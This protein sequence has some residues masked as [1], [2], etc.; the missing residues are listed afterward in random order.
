MADTRVANRT[1]VFAFMIGDRLF[2]TVMVFVPGKDAKNYEFTSS[3]PVQIFK[4]LE[5]TLRPLLER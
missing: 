5:P 3:L 1:A 2:G 4:D